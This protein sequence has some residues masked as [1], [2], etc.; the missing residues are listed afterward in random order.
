MAFMTVLWALV[1][2]TARRIEWYMLRWLCLMENLTC[3]NR[4]ISWPHY[5]HLLAEC[6]WILASFTHLPTADNVNTG[7]THCRKVVGWVQDTKF[8]MI[9]SQCWNKTT[10]KTN[11]DAQDKVTLKVPKFSRS[12]HNECSDWSKSSKSTAF[13]PRMAEY[14]NLYKRQ[15]GVL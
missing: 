13:E 7:L 10:D 11:R 5:R 4:S 6:P 8:I 9:C 15:G 14:H 12:R 2:R 1:P 3:G